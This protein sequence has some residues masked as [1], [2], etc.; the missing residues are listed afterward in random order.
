MH[1]RGKHPRREQLSGKPGKEGGREGN[2]VKEGGRVGERVSFS[3]SIQQWYSGRGFL[4][5]RMQGKC[6]L[7]KGIL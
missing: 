3:N 5:H 7:C 4:L 6:E 1:R 2:R